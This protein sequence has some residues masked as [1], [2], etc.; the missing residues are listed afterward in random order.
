MK[1]LLLLLALLTIIPVFST[2]NPIKNKEN[3]KT[4]VLVTLLTP[5]KLNKKVKVRHVIEVCESEDGNTVAYYA[6]GIFWT[7]TETYNWPET[8]PIISPPLTLSQVAEAC[9]AQNGNEN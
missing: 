5:T 6:N 3:R 4:D 8:G 2:T 7:E 1:K 9:D